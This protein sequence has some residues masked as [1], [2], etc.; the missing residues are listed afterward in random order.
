M[1]QYE[2]LLERSGGLVRFDAVYYPLYKCNR[3]RIVDFPTC[4]T[5]PAISINCPRLPRP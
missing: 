3:Q 1:Q 5:T 4:G 2:S